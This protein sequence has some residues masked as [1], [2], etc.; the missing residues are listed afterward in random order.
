MK[1]SIDYANGAIDSV[2]VTDDNGVML[3]KTRLNGKVRRRSPVAIEFFTETD[4]E[5]IANITAMAICAL[6]YSSA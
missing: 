6:R 3:A 1:T 2:I 4:R 5:T